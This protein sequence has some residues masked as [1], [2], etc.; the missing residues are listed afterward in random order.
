M[1][2]QTTNYKLTKPELTDAPPDITTLNSNWDTIDSKMKSI[3][4]SISNLNITPDGIGAVKKSGDTMTGTL[5][6]PQLHVSPTVCG[7]YIYD[8]TNTLNFRGGNP[9]TSEYGYMSLGKDGLFVGG[10]LVYHAG[11]KP[12][13]SDIGVN[14]VVTSTRT[15]YV[16][17]TGNDTSGTGGSSAPYATIG[18]ALSTIPKDLGG[19][20]VTVIISSGTYS[21][22]LVGIKWFSNGELRLQASDGTNKPV[23][24]NGIEVS[25]CTAHIVITN[26][27]CN[28]SATVSGFT[29]NTSTSVY[30][31]NCDSIDVG[32]NTS[33]GFV[34]DNLSTSY[35][36]DCS[37]TNCKQAIIC[38]NARCVVYS[39]SGT[40]QTGFYGTNGGDLRIRTHT[41]TYATAYYSEAGARIYTGSQSSLGNY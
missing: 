10:N 21:E 17:T 19:N 29:I 12:K 11:N 5:T 40:A 14:P 37:T 6:V 13:P 16:A 25:R 15:I 34:C 22:S 8:G 7:G 38:R 2:T 39:I 4:N 32:T 41:G 9:T 28:S 23:I 24:S 26:L 3:E 31:T 27:K 30:L 1:S 18:K 35:I 20:I 33:S 36:V